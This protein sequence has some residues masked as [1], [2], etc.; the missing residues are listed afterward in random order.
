MSHG[1]VQL[2]FSVQAQAGPLQSLSMIGEQRIAAQY[3]RALQWVDPA[4]ENRQV[5]I[6]PNKAEQR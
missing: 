2:S 3:S 6:G 5:N 4:E 1:G